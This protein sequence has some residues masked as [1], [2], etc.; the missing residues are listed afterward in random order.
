MCSKGIKYTRERETKREGEREIGRVEKKRR[1]WFKRYVRRVNKTGAHKAVDT[2]A[3]ES[4][5]ERDRAW[6]RDR[7]TGM[8]EMQTHR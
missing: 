2:V 4:D 5:R 7:N 1:I 6:E 8:T 3:T